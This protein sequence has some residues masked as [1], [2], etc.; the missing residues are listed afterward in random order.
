M[1]AAAYYESLELRAR[2]ELVCKGGVGGVFR[3]F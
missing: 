3:G 1:L 2:L